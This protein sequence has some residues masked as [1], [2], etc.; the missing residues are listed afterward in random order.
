M[1]V[2]VPAGV[3]LERL[4]ELV[5]VACGLEGAGEATRGRWH[6]SFGTV[7]FCPCRRVGIPTMGEPIK[8]TRRKRSHEGR[9]PT[10][11]ARPGRGERE[12]Q[13]GPR[14]SVK[15]TGLAQ[16][17]GQLEAVNRDLQPKSWASSV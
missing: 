14:H 13:R 11:H 1:A 3:G 6:L 16:K 9:I 7:T 5:A 10:T 2:K 12:L 8:Q 17:S 4:R 15:V